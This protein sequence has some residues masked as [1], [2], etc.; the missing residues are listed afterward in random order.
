MLAVSASRTLREIHKVKEQKV[1]ESLVAEWGKKV[2]GL[3]ACLDEMTCENCDY[4]PSDCTYSSVDDDSRE[5]DREKLKKDLKA[6][7]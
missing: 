1:V 6:D 3:T 2:M 5:V 4:H 7:P